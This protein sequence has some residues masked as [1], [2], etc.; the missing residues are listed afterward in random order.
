M[1]SHFSSI[2]FK[3]LESQEFINYFNL[4]YKNGSMI[5][6]KLG[7]YVKWE[8][9]EGIELWGQLGKNNTAIGM[10]PH[11]SGKSKLKIRIEKEIK[12]EDNTVLD[13]SLYA[14]AD[15]QENEQDGVYPFVFDLPDIATYGDIIF[16]Q[17]VTAQ[18]TGFA[19]EITVFKDN[20]EFENSQNCEVKFA[21]ESFIPAGLFSSDGDLSKADTPQ[22]LAILTGHIIE[23][24][25]IENP[26]TNNVFIYAKISTLGGEY[27]IV[28]DP[29]ILNGDIVTGGVVSGMFWL[30]GR[31]ASDS[32]E[33]LQKSKRKMPLFKL[34]K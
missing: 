5:R 20:E 30:S 6:T 8:L 18:I 1:A 28:V 25:E 19:H 10:N 14:W 9:G 11:F 31:I 17:I 15:P 21:S 27:D 34:F 29:E 22:A 4:A 33:K 3:I 7:T 24:Q 2:G 13:G 32:L 26:F 23:T 16:P 12:R